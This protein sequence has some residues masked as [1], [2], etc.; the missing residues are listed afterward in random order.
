MQQ[1]PQFMASPPTLHHPTPT[2]PPAPL[3]SHPPPGEYGGGASMGTGG[4]GDFQAFMP[5]QELTGSAATQLGVQFGKS[6]FVAGQQYVQQNMDKYVPLSTV[7]YYWNVNTSYVRRKILL[8]LFPFLHKSWA[9]LP[10]TFGENGKVES[11]RTAREDLNAPDLYIPV[12]ALVTYVIMVGIAT[13][14][15]QKFHPEVL[16]ITS[17][18]ALA[19]LAFEV[20]LVKLGFYL[21]NISND[22]P[23]LDL[24]A[25]SGYKFIGLILLQVLKVVLPT[26]GKWSVF[27]YVSLA[28]SF[29]L[30]RSLRYMVLPVDSSA[31]GRRRRVHFLFIIAAIQVFSSWLL[32]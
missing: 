20:M 1:Q 16:G 26:W 10:A 3:L 32:L 27:C 19:L 23:L 5:F 14:Q 31:Y 15:E 24:V 7:K 11:F 25:Y 12:M 6:A 30:L 2:H 22:A 28:V 13:G 17:S 9:R 21:L 18:T 29:F 4:G 8:V